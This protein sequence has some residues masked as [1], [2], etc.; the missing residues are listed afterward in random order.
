MNLALLAAETAETSTADTVGGTIVSL[1][2]L[3]L[4]GFCLWCMTR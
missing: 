2:V 1:G 3:I 4:I